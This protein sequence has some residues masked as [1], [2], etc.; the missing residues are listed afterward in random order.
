[1]AYVFLKGEHRLGPPPAP[2][3]CT[4]PRGGAH[5]PARSPDSD[6]IVPFRAPSS[7]DSIT[8]SPAEPGRVLSLHCLSRQHCFPCLLCLFTVLS[9]LVWTYF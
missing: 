7:D 5:P 2:R 6:V 3:M 1:M 8:R 9:S 4:L